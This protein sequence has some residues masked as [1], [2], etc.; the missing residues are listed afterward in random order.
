MI[1]TP[2]EKPDVSRL[3]TTDDELKEFLKPV[4]PTSPQEALKKFEVVD[5]F[6]MELVAAE[7]LGL[8]PGR[9]GVRRRRQPLRRRDARLSLQ[10]EAG[11]QTARHGAAAARHRRRRRVRQEH[12][13]R[14]RLLWAAGVAPWKGG[15]F[16]AAPPDIWYL[17]D[18]DGDFK[19]DVRGKVFTGF[20]TENQ[21]AMLNNLELGLDHKIYGATAG[22]GGTI[23]PADD[24]N[25]KP[26]SVDGRDF[27]FDPVTEEF[28]TITGTV[29]FGNTFDDWGNRFVCSESQPLHH[30]VLPEHYLARNP[31]LAVASAIQNIAAGPVPIFRISPI[32]RWRQIRCS[33]RIAKNERAATVAGASHHVVDAAAGVTIYRGGAYPPEF[34]GNVFVGDGQNNLVH[35]R[36]LDP[37]RR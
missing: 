8:Q 9:R 11:R 37:G 23:R 31:Y 22:N 28:E 3:D 30:I 27:R 18:T 26:I 4:P 14:R 2:R 21:Q 29:Q 10:A 34:Y 16:V 32:E 13:L 20:G 19:A 33:R 1:A 24:P 17:K 36:M 15:V 5:G 35:R 25:A 6:R 7:P 12:R